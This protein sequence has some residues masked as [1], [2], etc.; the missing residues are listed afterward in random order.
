L[1]VVPA[2]KQRL[3]LWVRSPVYTQRSNGFGADGDWL[4]PGARYP[5]P[6]ER[7]EEDYGFS[8]DARTRA[9]DLALLY[10]SSQDDASQPLRAPGRTFSNVCWLLQA[11]GSPYRIDHIREPRERGRKWGVDYQVLTRFKR[12]LHIRR[13]RGDDVIGRWS[14]V[15]G[16]LQGSHGVWEVPRP[17]WDAII[18]RLTD[19]NPESQPVFAEAIRD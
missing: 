2:P 5:Q 11:V 6:S 14:P 19:L 17:I 8:C 13:M 1:T 15:R 18:S 9:G 16:N 7:S 10:R 3:W 12:P 4:K